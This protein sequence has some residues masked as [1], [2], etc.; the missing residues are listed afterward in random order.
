MIR[1]LR[2]KDLQARGIINS[3]PMLKRRVERDG[4]PVGVM[5][6]PNQRAW[7]EAEVEKWIRSR[8]TSGTALKGVAKTRTGNPGKRK[9]AAS[10]AASTTT[11]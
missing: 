7:I 5:V 11:A 9:A 10:T 1:F 8:P 3:W 4:F 6:G 2:F